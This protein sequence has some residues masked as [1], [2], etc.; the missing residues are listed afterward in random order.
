MSETP[1]ITSIG[2]ILVNARDLDRAIAFY[3]DTMGLPFLFQAGTMAF[4]DCGGVRLMIAPPDKPEV[5]HAA[6]ILYYKTADIDAAHAT[7]VAKGVHVEEAPQFVAP[8]PDHDLWFAFYKDSEEN[9]FALMCE[10]KR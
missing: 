1:G 8:M 7:L 3:R 2:Q 6:S 9:I 5:D 10:K 4:F